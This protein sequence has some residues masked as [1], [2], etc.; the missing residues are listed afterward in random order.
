[1]LSVDPSSITNISRL[2]YV[3]AKMLSRASLIVWAL[4]YVGMMTLTRGFISFVELTLDDFMIRLSG[5]RPDELPIV[6]CAF[7]F[8]I[9]CIIPARALTHRLQGR[10]EA[11]HIS[12][13]EE[14]AD[15]LVM[16][17]FRQA[18]HTGSDDGPAEG[19]RQHSRA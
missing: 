3:W 12:G 8:E 2:V 10:R 15:S 6:G 16:N 17:D 4:L 13:L 18:P 5:L 14:D 9:L 11:L 19:Q 1:M 7:L